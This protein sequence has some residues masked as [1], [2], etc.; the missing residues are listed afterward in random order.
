MKTNKINVVLS[1]NKSQLQLG[2]ANQISIEEARINGND[3]NMQNRANGVTHRC[4][5]DTY[6]YLPPGVVKDPA[7]D[8]KYMGS[9][10]SGV[11]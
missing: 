4:L 5:V 9:G 10:A 8:A 1:L 3:W 11:G 2:N 7:I 6:Y